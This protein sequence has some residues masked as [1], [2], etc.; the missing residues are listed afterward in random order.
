MV[1]PR[2]HN[3]PDD[4]SSRREG[5]GKKALHGGGDHTEQHERANDPINETQGHTSCSG[6]TEC[7]LW[8]HIQLPPCKLGICFEIFFAGAARHLRGKRGSR[9]LLVPV[10]LLEV[11]ADVLL[12]VRILRPSGSVL[13]CR[14]EAG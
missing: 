7:P 2:S 4:Q 12:V 11:V 8:S 3:V 10:N 14:P 5:F 1:L 6:K 13:I 9:W